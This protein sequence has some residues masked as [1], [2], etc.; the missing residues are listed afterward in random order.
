MA[1]IKDVEISKEVISLLTKLSNGW[2]KSENNRMLSNK[3]GNSS[4]LLEVYSVKRLKLIWTIDILEQNSTYFQVLKIWD[5]LPGY[6]I[7]KLSKQIDIHFGNYTVDLMNR[8]KCKH[9]ERYKM[10]TLI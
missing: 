1:R 6:H 2:R 3:G 9:V 5:I 10:S 4:V 8:C 7:P